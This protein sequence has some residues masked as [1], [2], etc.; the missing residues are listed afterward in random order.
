MNQQNNDSQVPLEDELII[1]E[2]EL[3]KDIENMEIT[4]SEEIAAD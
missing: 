1:D 3:S 2:S 4:V